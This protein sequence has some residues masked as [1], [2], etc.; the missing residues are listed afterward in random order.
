LNIDGRNIELVSNLYRRNLV[1]GLSLILTYDYYVRSSNLFYFQ[2]VIVINSN[3]HVD[4]MLKIYT[5]EVTLLILTI[6][7]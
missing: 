6:L 3:D 7:G 4:S 2:I 5:N 1:S